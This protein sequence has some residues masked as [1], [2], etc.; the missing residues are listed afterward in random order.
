M[1]RSHTISIQ[2]DYPCEAAYR[3]L[4]QPRNYG[5]WAAVD[6]A[7]YKPV[8]SDGDW[9]AD[10]PFGKRHFRFTPANA[11][12]VLDHAVFVPGEPLLYTPMRVVPN[13]GGT[14]LTFIF[15]QRPGM[16]EAE[17]LSAVEWI[18]TDFLTL[19][20]LLEARRKSG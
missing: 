7:S 3:F 5:E 6:K 14:E 16:S 1:R 19:K 12:G 2:I 18:T 9:Q 8:G 4:S 10:T 11:F 20:S 17:F 13:E 15:Y